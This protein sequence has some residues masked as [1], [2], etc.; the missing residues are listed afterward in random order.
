MINQNLVDENV[1]SKFKSRVTVLI[2][3]SYHYKSYMFSNMCFKTIKQIKDFLH[4]EDKY[5]SI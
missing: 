2:Y 3:R 5:F 1:I 4:L